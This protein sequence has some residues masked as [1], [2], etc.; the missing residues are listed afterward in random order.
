M[1][2]QMRQ[3]SYLEF[4]SSQARME[5]VN[6]RMW[7]LCLVLIVSLLGTNGAWIYYES[8]FE[9][10]VTTETI[11]QEAQADGDSDVQLIGGD[12]NGSESKADINENNQN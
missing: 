3:I 4:E 1:E 10:V 8:Q 7:I 9:D 12:Y 5:R 6:R 11:T 2:E